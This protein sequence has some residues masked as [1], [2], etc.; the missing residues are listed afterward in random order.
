M[1]HDDVAEQPSK[2]ILGERGDR[3]PEHRDHRN[4]DHGTDEPVEGLL[5]FAHIDPDDAVAAQLQQQPRQD[6]RD[7]RRRLGL[8]VDEPGMERKDRQSHGKGD[9]EQPGNQ[10]RQRDR[11]YGVMQGHH[12]E[13]P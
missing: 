2:I 1:A 9:K 8:G 4:H 7:R 11:Q 12:V 5:E 6:H 13:G 10:S 3:A